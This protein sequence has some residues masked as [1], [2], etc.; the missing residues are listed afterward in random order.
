MAVLLALYSLMRVSEF[1]FLTN[2]CYVKEKRSFYIFKSKT[3]FYQSASVTDD[4]CTGIL[5]DYCNN[6]A[7]EA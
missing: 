7:T 4:A 5:D 6:L 3:G 1:I 2:G